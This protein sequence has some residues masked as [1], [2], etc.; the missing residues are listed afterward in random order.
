MAHYRKN[1]F[2]TILLYTPSAFKKSNFFRKSRKIC[3]D[4]SILR[5]W[6]APVKDPFFS[7]HKTFRG[8]N[9][10]SWCQNMFFDA[11]GTWLDT[12]SPK[13]VPGTFL[14]LPRNEIFHW[15][16]PVTQNAG[17]R[18]LEFLHFTTYPKGGFYTFSWDIYINIYMYINTTYI[19]HTKI[20][21]KITS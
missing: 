6:H 5:N 10:V 3:R 13:S 14:E 19:S 17:S 16:V 21:I 20:K 12:K 18:N 1:G 4:T 11:V 7:V 9:F 2:C 8:T 15:R